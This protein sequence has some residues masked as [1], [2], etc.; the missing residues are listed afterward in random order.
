MTDELAKQWMEWVSMGS[1]FYNAEIGKALE[2]ND[3]VAR[4]FFERAKRIDPEFA[5]RYYP[6]FLE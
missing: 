2:A 1:E 4:N 5:R 6:G 3:P